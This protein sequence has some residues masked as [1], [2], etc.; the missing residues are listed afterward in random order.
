[1]DDAIGAFTA[2]ARQYCAFVEDTRATN[3]WIFAQTCLSEVLGLYHLALRL[4][5]VEPASGVLLEDIDHQ[6]S[7]AV[8]E[9]LARRIAQD[10]Y[11]MVG[12]PLESEPPEPVVGLLS[13]DL[14][15]IWRDL[16]PGVEAIGG[17][18]PDLIPDV[19]WHWRFSFETHWGHHAV[20][21]IG[22]LHA[23]CSG[24]FAD[25]SRPPRTPE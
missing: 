23:L 11:W 9:N 12:E 4:P 25:A 15:D 7:T 17:G 6:T 3:S 1:M 21:A 20:S 24:A 18:T 22:A 2:K 13:D 14:A 19:V 8:R 16:K 5:E 10:S